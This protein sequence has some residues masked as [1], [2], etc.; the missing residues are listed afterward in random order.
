MGFHGTG[1]VGDY[2]SAAMQKAIDGMGNACVAAGF[3]K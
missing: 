1:D 3:S 2:G